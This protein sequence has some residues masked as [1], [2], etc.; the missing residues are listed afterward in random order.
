M[1]LS[2][3]VHLPVP[4]A[5]AWE[6]QLDHA[7]WSAHIPHFRVVEPRGPFGLGAQVV[8]T[9]DGLGAVEWTVI[10][11][12]GTSFAWESRRPGLRMEGSHRVEPEGDGAR[13]T[14]GLVMEGVVGAALGFLMRRSIEAAV[15]AE[16][17][18]FLRW[19]T[20]PGSAAPA[21]SGR[22]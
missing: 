18:A 14:L 10:R 20:A 17:D 1:V 5:R 9:Q 15:Q 16:A 19:A 6:L 22:P 21:S 4:V 13:L 8:I 2:T 11:L 3:S 12:E 7:H